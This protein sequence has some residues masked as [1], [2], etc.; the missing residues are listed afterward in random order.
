MNNATHSRISTAV[1]RATAWLAA[2]SVTL[3]I[4]LAAFDPSTVDTEGRRRPTDANAHCT[5]NLAL[6]APASAP[7]SS[8]VLDPSLQHIDQAGAQ[9]G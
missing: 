1:E 7:A 6:P 3:G 9:H 8:G 2:A 5:P 4:G